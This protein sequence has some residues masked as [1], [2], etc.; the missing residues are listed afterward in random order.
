MRF[1]RIA[2]VAIGLSMAGLLGE[3]RIGESMDKYY[4]SEPV[5]EVGDISSFANF[6]NYIKEQKPR[7]TNFIADSTLEGIVSKLDSEVRL[8]APITQD[9]VLTKINV[10]SKK[11]AYAISGADARGLMQLTRSAWEQVEDSL[12]YDTH[13][14]IPEDNISVGMKYLKFIYSFL[15]A[16]MDTNRWD[17]LDYRKRLDYISATY[18]TGPRTL[19][20]A[21]W[22]IAGL[23][24]ETLNHIRKMNMQLFNDSSFAYTHYMDKDYSPDSSAADTLL[25]IA[26][27]M[28]TR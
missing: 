3:H 4:S 26:D 28:K 16:N 22:N 18:N 17:E 23:S 5:V 9:Y 21:E 13:W 1:S 15:K 25:A 19:K 12:D 2:A 14:F 20:D 27:S 7:L 6:D 10:E 24:F 8:P 11:D